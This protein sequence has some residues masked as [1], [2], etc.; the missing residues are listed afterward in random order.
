MNLRGLRYFLKT[1]EHGSITRA[2]AA[3]NMTQP[4][5]TQHL[6]QLEDYFETPLF[7]RHGRGSCLPRPAV[8]SG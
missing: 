5:L 3:L 1:A 6:R 2:A 4:S 7:M 8:S